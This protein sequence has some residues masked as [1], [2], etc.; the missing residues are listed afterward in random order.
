MEVADGMP[1]LLPYGV[2]NKAYKEMSNLIRSWMEVEHL[3]TGLP[4]YKLR[5]ST[6]DE[7]VVEE[8][9]SGYF[10]LSDGIK[11]NDG[12]AITLVDPSLMFD[13]RTDLGYPEGFSKTSI[14]CMKQSEQVV[15]NKVPCAFTLK[16][17][18]IE[19]GDTLTINS[20][21]GYSND[22]ETISRFADGIDIDGFVGQQCAITKN[23][24]EKISDEISTQTGVKAYDAYIRQ[25][26]LD[27]V[28][29]GG[30]QYF[31][32][33][34]TKSMFTIYSQESM[35]GTLKGIIISSL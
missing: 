11:D 10:Y 18:E 22:Y 8:V 16:S 13:Y 12:K 19:P 25:N 30:K 6:K 23:E 1:A 32:K 4:F 24:V 3:E 17:C 26:Y 14:D 33:A 31:L 20:V 34:R 29:R 21:I 27:N 9:K 5:S 7:A 28:L 35:G 2:T 15:A